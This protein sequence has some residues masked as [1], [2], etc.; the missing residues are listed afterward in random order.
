MNPKQRVKVLASLKG[1]GKTE[2]KLTTEVMSNIVK[3]VA[4]CYYPENAESEDD[5]K[6]DLKIYEEILQLAS[7]IKEENR[8]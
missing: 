3:D 1:L 6:S 5:L 8:K 4:E 2:Q 7:D